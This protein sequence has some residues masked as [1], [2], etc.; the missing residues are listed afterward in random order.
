MWRGLRGG[1][2]TLALEPRVVALHATDT[3]RPVKSKF[4]YRPDIDGLRAL[5]VVSVVLFHLGVG[6]FAG[7]FV[8]VDVFFAI[9]GFLITGLLRSEL[10]AGTMSFPRFYLRRARRLFPALFFTLLTS[11]IVGSLL[12]SPAHFAAFAKSLAAALG[13]FSNVTFWLSSNYF[14][15]AS[16]LKPLL[17]TWS[18]GVEEQFYMLWPLALWTLWRIGKDRATIAALLIATCASFVLSD[19]WVARGAP[20][21]FYLAPSR[22][23]EFT[24]GALMLWV[25][26]DGDGGDWS[27]E[28]LAAAGLAAI[29]LAVFRFDSSTPFPGRNA[30]IPCLGTAA[31]LVSGGRA[32]YVGA[33]LRSQL[34]VGIGLISYSLYLAHWP[35]YVFSRYLKLAPLT[36]AE[37][38]GVIVASFAVA[39]GMYFFVERPFRA[40]RERTPRLTSKTFVFAA[41]SLVVALAI[42]AISAWQS[43][44]WRWR[45]SRELAH[46]I[47]DDQAFAEARRQ[48]IRNGDCRS[49]PASP[50]TKAE[51]RGCLVRVEGKRNVLVIGDSHSVDLSMALRMAYPDE[52]ILLASHP[53]CIPISSRHSNPGSPCHDVMRLLRS[54]FP[55]LKNVDGV[56]LSGRWP[57][58]FE[59]LQQDVDYY[60]SLGLPVVVFG[61]AAEFDEDL[62]TLTFV[63]GRVDDLDHFASTHEVQERRTLD[64]AMQ[65]YFAQHAVPY[66]SKIDV[67]CGAGACPTTDSSNR[68]II[69]D[70]GH[71]GTGAAERFATQLRSRYGSTSDLFT[72]RADTPPIL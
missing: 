4:D 49:N 20:A 28:L 35:I 60:R 8:G 52:N 25:E 9:S 16:R 72:L 53:G 30:L 71:W 33:V 41:V 5:A 18:L 58:D 48:V 64:L 26:R 63:H 14:D 6:G 1:F 69:H 38:V 29:G 32:R 10:A 67:F 57:N 19:V 7:G 45:M 15:T 2:T 3:T 31:L 43:S 47:G 24:L 34:F 23:G 51:Y 42:P 37:S 56:I 44:G 50:V 61:P 55:D 22:V 70:Y 46:S 13:S 40:S 68:L 62:L 65:H 11:F 21:A 66:V 39:T 54:E 27:D 36:T 12:L 17:H 59:P